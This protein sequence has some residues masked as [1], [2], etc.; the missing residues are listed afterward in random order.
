M[1]Q[2]L[3]ARS[4]IASIY[5]T[6][7]PPPRSV[8][9]TL[10]WRLF[11]GLGMRIRSSC[12]N[13]SSKWTPWCTRR[14][15]ESPFLYSY[16][17]SRNA[18]H[19]LNN[20]TVCPAKVGPEGLLKAPAEGHGGTSLFFLPAVEV[21][22]AIAAWAAKILANLSVA[23]N[24]DCLPAHRYGPS[25]CNP[26]LPI[27]LRVRKHLGFDRNAHSRLYKRFGRRREGCI[28]PFHLL[29]HP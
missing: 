26:V 8:R 21:A 16:G 18:S 11:L 9:A 23:I 4:P 10:I 6:N 5:P 28:A 24:R 17:K 22:V 27:P 15:Q 20:A 19:S 13:R 3:S 2:R 7:S 29:D 14:P 1:R 12:T 25:R